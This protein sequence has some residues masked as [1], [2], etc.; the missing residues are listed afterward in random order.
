MS[1][2]SWKKE[3]YPVN[4]ASK[5]ATASPLAAAKHSLRKWIGLRPE[6]LEAH[7]LWNNGLYKI[8]ECGTNDE[9]FRIDS[10]SCALCQLIKPE[11]NGQGCGECPLAIVRG[12]APC[13]GKKSNESKSPY[14]ASSPEP[15]IGWLEKAIDY[16]AK[17]SKTKKVE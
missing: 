14:A 4:A 7:G 15:M 2:A 13:D 1:I 10:D 12:G 9:A 8:L 11:R 5:R 16:A 6:N 3:F 17:V